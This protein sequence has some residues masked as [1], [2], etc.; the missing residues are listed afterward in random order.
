MPVGDFGMRKN[1]RPKG[2]IGMP[3]NRKPKKPTGTPCYAPPT[4]KHKNRAPNGTRLNT[5][6]VQSVCD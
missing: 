4:R 2:L 5:L 3:K 1:Y 6:A